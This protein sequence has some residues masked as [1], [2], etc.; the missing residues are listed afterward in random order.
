M[1]EKTLYDILEVSPSASP[2]VI[3]A[4]YERLSAKHDPDNTLNGATPGARILVD[5]I[6]EAFLTLSNPGKRI[7]YD[8]KLAARSQPIFH[9]IQIV[10]PFW[11][12]PKLIMLALIIIVGGSYYYSYKK[13]EMKLAAEKAIAEAQAREAEEKARAET[14]Q[15]RLL[16]RQKQ[17]ERIAE[18]RTRR[19]SERAFRQFSSEQ[20]RMSRSTDITAMRERQDRQRA[21]SQRQREEQQAAMAARAQAARDRAELCRMERERYGRALSC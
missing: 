6:K 4:A 14:E 11:T 16:L 10:E 15:T 20:Q 7:E 8:K 21:D 17:E 12:T 1:S 18:E 3:R 2:E 9:N 13:N 19:E 5:A